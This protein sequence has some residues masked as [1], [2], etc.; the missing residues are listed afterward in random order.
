MRKFVFLLTFALVLTLSACTTNEIDAPTIDTP[1]VQTLKTLATKVSGYSTG[2]GE[3]VTHIDWKDKIVTPIVPNIP[4]K[5]DSVATERDTTGAW[6]REWERDSIAFFNIVE[7]INEVAEELDILADTTYYADKD[8]DF[9]KYYVE[10]PLHPTQKVFDAD[11]FLSDYATETYGFYYYAIEN[12]LPITIEEIAANENLLVSEKILLAVRLGLVKGNGDYLTYIDGL[13]TKVMAQTM[14]ECQARWRR[15]M[16]RCYYEWKYTGVSGWVSVGVSTLGTF[17]N[18]P[19]VKWGAWAT[20]IAIEAWNG[21]VR[22]WARMQCENIVDNN[23]IICA[24][25]VEQ[26]Y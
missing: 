7:A 6:K 8:I 26:L 17:V 14:A 23:L 1:T 21:G 22:D 5:K 11:S 16:Q 9:D 18:H 24:D 10:S 20:G 12:D 2:R 19:Y 15:G 3:V 13:N 25:Y 4:G